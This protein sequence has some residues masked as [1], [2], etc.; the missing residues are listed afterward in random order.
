MCSYIYLGF[1]TQSNNVFLPFTC[2]NRNVFAFV[3]LNEQIYRVFKGFGVEQQSSNVLEHNTFNC[4]K[5]ITI[6]NK[7]KKKKREK[8]KKS[9][10]QEI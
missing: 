9:H 3:S 7:L 6:S 10:N 2:N 4:N 1:T 8:E 5:T